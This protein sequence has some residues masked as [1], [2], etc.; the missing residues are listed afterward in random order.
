[1]EKKMLLLSVVLMVVVLCGSAALALPP[2]GPPT[3]GLRK[4]QFSAGA[5]YSYSKMDLKFNEG[6]GRVSA[7]FD[8]VPIPPFPIAGKIPSFTIKNAKV[9]QVY[10]NLGYGITD[11]WEAF[12]RLGGANV[13]CEL[14]DEEF[15]GDYG[16]AIGFGTKVT[17]LEQTPELKWG[18]LFQMS[19]ANSDAD[20]SISDEEYDTDAEL[21]ATGEIDFYEIQI[22]VGPT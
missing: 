22:A 21:S 14:F 4:G 15:N 11:N 17:F 6:K 13:D 12:L 20:F 2:M 7:Y 3:A 10:A 16:F 19:W 8:G 5:D 18:G 1:M 9:N